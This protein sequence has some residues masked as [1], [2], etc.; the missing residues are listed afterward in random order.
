MGVACRILIPSV[1]RTVLTV[2]PN[3]PPRRPSPDCHPE[4]SPGFAP[5]PIII[6]N[7]APVFVPALPLSSRT[8][9]RFL[10]PPLPSS[11]RIQPRFSSP[12]SHCHPEPGCRVLADGGEGS[13]VRFPLCPLCCPL[14]NGA[15]SIAKSS[16]VG[17]PRSISQIF[18][19]RRQP[20]ISFSRA[21]ASRIS[22]N[23]SRHTRR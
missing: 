7:P 14:V 9:P 19:S 18:F 8:R 16:Q 10:P 2:T 11:S 22:A 21:I 17:L 15:K 3:P 20:L 6:P 23:G 5:P 12:P 13:A 4:S 1:A